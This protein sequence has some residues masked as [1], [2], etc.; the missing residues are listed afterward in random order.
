MADLFWDI[1]TSYFVLSVV[2]FVLVCALVVGYFPLLKWFPVVGEYVPVARL[3]AF[4]AV[5]LLCLLIGFRIADERAVA[6]ALRSK[7]EASAIDLEATQQAANEAEAARVELAKQSQADQERI[8]AYEKAL[9]ANPTGNCALS[10][11][12]LRWLRSAPTG[13]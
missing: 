8:A 4:L 13:R 7:L 1:A 6:A 9:A 12:D 5:A 2:G 10:D 11:D 3:I